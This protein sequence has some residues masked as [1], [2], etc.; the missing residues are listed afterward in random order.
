V[1]DAAWQAPCKV[2]GVLV[3]AESSPIGKRDQIVDELPTLLIIHFLFT[4]ITFHTLTL[5]KNHARVV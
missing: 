3:R 5:P 4:D 2:L 1:K